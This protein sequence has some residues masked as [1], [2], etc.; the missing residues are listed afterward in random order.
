MRK[1]ISSNGQ[2]FERLTNVEYKLLEHDRKFDEVFRQF[3]L[4]GNIK[5]RIFFNGQIYDAYSIIIEFICS[6]TFCII[7]L[8]I[9]S[10]SVTV[11]NLL[12]I[13]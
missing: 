13:L 10:I 7:Y 1:F 12:K 3:Q 11:F 6:I 8:C 2:G 5:Q 9:S 4:E